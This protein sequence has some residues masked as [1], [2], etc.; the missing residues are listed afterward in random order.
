MF[1]L[2]LREEYYLMHLLKKKIFNL[3]L[4]MISKSLQTVVIN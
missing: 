4:Y 2:F 1:H 3:H